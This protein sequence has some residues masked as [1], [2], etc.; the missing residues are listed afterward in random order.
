MPFSIQNLSAEQVLNRV[1]RFSGRI[2]RYGPSQ[3][4][5][6]T[7]AV[8]L[9]HPS[10]RQFSSQRSNK[11]DMS[12]YISLTSGVMKMWKF[13]PSNSSYLLQIFGQFSSLT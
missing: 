2:Y 1:N 7:E 13:F 3:L 12:T 5:Y 10:S 11:N 9:L 6:Y 8:F 4:E